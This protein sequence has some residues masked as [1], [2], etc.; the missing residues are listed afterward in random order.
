MLRTEKIRQSTSSVNSPILFVPK[1]HGCGLRLYVDYR[2]LNRVSIANRYPLPLMSEL[3][4]RIRGAQFFTKI[5]HMYGYHI[6]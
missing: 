1:P 6:V 4:D 5:D 2:G 3:Q